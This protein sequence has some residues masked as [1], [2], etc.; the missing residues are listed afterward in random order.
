AGAAARAGQGVRGRR[1]A[2]RR[3]GLAVSVAVAA[4]AIAGRPA[5]GLHGKGIGVTV[6]L[7]A[8]AATLAL[9]IGGRFS[10]RGYGFQAAVISAM[11]AAGV[12]LAALQPRGA[13]ELAG[14]AAVW[15]A[16]AR[17]PSGLGGA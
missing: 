4:S 17:L 10:A 9:A 16:V 6:A 13:T 3:F 14:G 12:A 11:G 15:L 5:P 2:L 8:F 1:A 7:C